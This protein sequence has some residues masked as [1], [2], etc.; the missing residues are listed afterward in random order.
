MKSF[1][2]IPSKLFNGVLLSK[3]EQEFLELAKLDE[4]IL[5]QKMGAAGR[6]TETELKA[7]DDFSQCPNMGDVEGK[8][9]FFYLHDS[10]E[11]SAGIRCN[12]PEDDLEAGKVIVSQMGVYFD[13]VICDTVRE[14]PLFGYKQEAIR[15]A[16]QCVEA[17]VK[18][19][20]LIDERI[21]KP[22]VALRS[23]QMFNIYPR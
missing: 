4:K 3:K 16:A 10:I 17:L 9:P 5:F 18:K 7:K 13:K 15:L 21:I 11:F 20:P 23:Q 2:S 14:S 12:L 22:F 6:A 19:F 1:T 8:S